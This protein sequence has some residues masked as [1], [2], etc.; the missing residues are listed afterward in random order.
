MFIYKIFTSFGRHFEQDVQRVKHSSSDLRKVNSGMSR[1]SM[2]IWKV[3]PIN[4][5]TKML[6]IFKKTMTK[7][8]LKTW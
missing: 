1:T 2:T 6:E 5:L 4:I 7:I 3:N 8:M